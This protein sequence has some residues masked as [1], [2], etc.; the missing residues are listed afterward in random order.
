MDTSSGQP[1]TIII[2]QMDKYRV[3]ALALAWNYP[4]TGG[5]TRYLP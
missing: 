2:T 5:V 1:I 3:L 4:A